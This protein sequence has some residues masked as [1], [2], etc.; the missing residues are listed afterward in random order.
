MQLEGKLCVHVR[1]AAGLPAADSM[2][3]ISDPYARVVAGGQRQQTKALKATREP[4]WGES[5]TFEGCLGDFVAA[6]LEVAVYHADLVGEH[7]SLG[8]TQVTVT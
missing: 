6:P 8:S 2:N 7:R 1:R 5:L 3:G 4:E